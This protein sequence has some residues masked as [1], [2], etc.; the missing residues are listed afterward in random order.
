MGT[1]CA[2]L[3]MFIPCFMHKV[4][5]IHVDKMYNC[6]ILHFMCKKLENAFYGR[7]RVIK[8]SIAAFFFPSNEHIAHL[9]E[10]KIW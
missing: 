7:S 5:N 1:R 8:Y 4:Q 9:P 2:S 10:A 3:F 6:V